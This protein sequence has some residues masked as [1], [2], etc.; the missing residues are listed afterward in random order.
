MVKPINAKPSLYAW[1]YELLKEK[2]KT[3]GYALLLHGSMS[4]DLDLVAIPWSDKASE[5]SF[6]E[7]IEEAVNLL[8]GYIQIH[9]YTDP[10]DIPSQYSV[11]HH[12]RRQ[13]VI[14]INRG[15]YYGCN[16]EMKYLEDG[17]YYVD[18]SAFIP[19]DIT[20]EKEVE[21]S[22]WGYYGLLAIIIGI[23]SIIWV[24]LKTR[25]TI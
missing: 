4:R 25:T 20:N 1:Y 18:I 2:A 3:H 13:Y 24:L 6:G 11:T 14:N 5:E 7:F 23:I 12:G 16:S 22:R 9:N 8:G 15:G 10:S 17:Q 21:R 19:G